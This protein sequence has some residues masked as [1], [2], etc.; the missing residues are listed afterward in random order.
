MSYGNLKECNGERL[1]MKRLDVERIDANLCGAT[2]LFI[3]DSNLPVYIN[4][5][6]YT[7]GSTGGVGAPGPTGATGRTGPTGSN[8]TNGT[9]GAT[10]AQG[11]TGQPGDSDG[12]QMIFLG[13]VTNIDSSLATY[14]GAYGCSTTEFQSDREMTRNCVASNLRVRLQNPATGGTVEITLKKNFV[15]TLLVATVPDGGTSATNLATNV[16]FVAGDTW[17]VKSISTG[18]AMVCNVSFQ[19]T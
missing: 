14:I 13:S 11:P 18:G 8:G 3:A 17:S 1:K 15:D 12:L 9:N 2:G 6:L 19:V 10:G 16:S 7:P 4:N 5:L